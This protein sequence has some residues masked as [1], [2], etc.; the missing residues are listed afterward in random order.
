MQKEKKNA[1]ISNPYKLARRQD[2]NVLLVPLG[3]I[4]GIYNEICT[5]G[6]QIFLNDIQ[7][8]QEIRDRTLFILMKHHNS[9]QK[10]MTKVL[11]I[12]DLRSC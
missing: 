12:N 8:D 6:Y 11:S 3:D 7:E 9:S 10:G 5:G 4:C 2:V 1:A